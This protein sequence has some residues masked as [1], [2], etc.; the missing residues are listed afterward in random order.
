L[1]L[2][3][4][5]PDLLN[6]INTTVT[7]S[8]QLNINKRDPLIKRLLNI[9]HEKGFTGVLE[10]MSVYNKSKNS[11]EGMLEIIFLTKILKNCPDLL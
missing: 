3:D 1:P 2:N 11:D 10:E 9:Y 4:F 8:I 5:L 6:E 7:N